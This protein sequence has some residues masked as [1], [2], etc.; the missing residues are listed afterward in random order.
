MRV[1]PRRCLVLLVIALAFSWASL[2]TGQESDWVRLGKL[3]VVTATALTAKPEETAKPIQHLDAGTAVSWVEG[4][5]KNNFYRVLLPNR[6]LINARISFAY[7]SS[8]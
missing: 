8:Q 1:L 2:A 3:T 6:L 7:G 5:K 4:E